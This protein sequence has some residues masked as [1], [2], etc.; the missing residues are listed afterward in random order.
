M[1]A[2]L[3]VITPVFVCYVSAREMLRKVRLLYWP[4]DIILN[5]FVCLFVCLSACLA[6]LG[7]ADFDDVLWWMLWDC[8]V[9]VHA[10]IIR[11]N[12]VRGCGRKWDGNRNKLCGRPPQ[13]ARPL[14]PYAC[15]MYIVSPLAGLG[16]AYCG[17]LPPTACFSFFPDHRLITST[18]QCIS[19]N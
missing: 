14:W 6:L 13:Y 17:G 15:M 11:A 10:I 5:R 16:G 18:Y 8:M 4:L 12:G 9:N 7:T 1:S 2:C 19:T 3:L